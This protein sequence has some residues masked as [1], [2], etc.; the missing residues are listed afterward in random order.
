MPVPIRGRRAFTLIELIVVLA[1]VALL[2]GLLLPAVQKARAAAARL[3][4]TN[5]LKQIGLATHAFNDAHGDRLPN[6]AEPINPAYPATPANPW[7]QATGPFF[8]LLPYLEGGALYA[9]I[10]AIDS[11]ATYDATMPTPG[12][13]SAVVKTFRSPADPS[14]PT[15]QV[16]I[17]GSPVPINN[18]L[19]GTASYAY[20]PRVFRTVPL[21]LGSSFPDGTSNTL[22]YSEKYQICGRGTGL[23][24]IQNYWFGSH[25]GNSAALF[26]APVL[27]GAELL[28]PSGQ[29]AGGNFLPSNLGV[30]PA[31]C[32]PSA[33]SGP[34]AGG[35][36][37]GLA[38]GSVRFLGA[39]GAT[40]RLGPPPLA[41][42]CAAYDRPASGASVDL[43][44]YVWSALLTPDG[45]EP[46]SFE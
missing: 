42:A 41:G 27:P 29:Y 35:I 23:A 4:S 13:R 19:W 8:Q 5:N 16:V 36:L 46:F 24:M 43:R 45:G 26:W 7:N 44:G 3:S 6:P 40:A 38:D 1:I 33:P 12:G 14:N 34:H 18:G 20:N 2:T 28:A 22:L 21:G 11:Q 25:V 30:A 15:G 17:T 37:I 10:R 31:R 39:A 32:D 9:S